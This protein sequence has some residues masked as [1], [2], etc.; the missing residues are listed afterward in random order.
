MIMVLC[1]M[2]SSIAEWKLRTK[3]QEENETV[4]DQ[5]GKPT[6]RPTMRG[7]FFKFQRITE[8]ITQ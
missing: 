4:P 6:K 1:L 5:K 7:I 3:L 8:L 2:I